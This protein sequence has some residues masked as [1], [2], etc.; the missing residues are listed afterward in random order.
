MKSVNHTP[1]A[2]NA[3]NDNNDPN[4]PN[5]PNDLN[6]PNNLNALS[7]HVCVCLR[8]KFRFTNCERK[9]SYSTQDVPKITK[10]G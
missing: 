10:P 3:P 5:D 9:T 4:G 7:A 1:N 2:A 8:L 6:G